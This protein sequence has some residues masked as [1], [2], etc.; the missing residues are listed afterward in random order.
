M[1]IEAIRAALEAG[2]TGGLW[3]PVQVGDRPTKFA[4][5]NDEGISLLT[6]VEEEGH[7]FAAVYEDADASFIAACNPSA[8]R[9][10]LDRLDAAEK[11]VQWRPI[12]TAPKDGTRLLLW[13]GSEVHIGRCVG[14]GM[15]RDG[16]DWWRSESHQVFKVAGGR[17]THWMPLPAAPAAMEGE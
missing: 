6:L 11:A 15:S 17:P 5:A 9:E 2:P 12:E 14:A 1:S 3:H 4:V 16:G 8:I 7:D 13:W 10:L